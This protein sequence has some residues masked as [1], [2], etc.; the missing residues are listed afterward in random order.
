MKNMENI[1]W[2]INFIEVCTWSVNRRNTSSTLVSGDGK[3]E[4]SCGGEKLPTDV[5]YKTLLYLL[6]LAQNN[7][8]NNGDWMRIIDLTQYTPSSLIKGI[9]GTSNNPNQEAIDRFYDTLKR[10]SNMRIK[11][12]QSYHVHDASG[13]KGK[14]A[15]SFNVLS[16]SRNLDPPRIAFD[17]LFL[18]RL[19]QSLHYRNLSLNEYQRISNPTAMRLFELLEK[20]FLYNRPWKINAKRLAEK[21]G[22]NAKHISHITL[23][24]QIAI[25]LIN[26]ATGNRYELEMKT[27]DGKET[28]NVDNGCVT[29]KLVGTQYVPAF[30]KPQKKEEQKKTSKPSPRP[31][32]SDL[33]TTILSAIPAT[34][35]S[36]KEVTRILDELIRMKG[37][38]AA[39][40]IIKYCLSK[41]PRSFAAYLVTMSKKTNLAILAETEIANGG[42]LSQRE[43]QMHYRLKRCLHYGEDFFLEKCEKYEMDPV[44]VREWIDG[45]D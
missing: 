3:Y 2:D 12:D 19:R 34:D 26:E 37:E 8:D 27:A 31:F 10:Y 1:R 11:F 36:D 14:V 29:F 41:K 35:R 32:D 4:V 42:L 13:A 6:C 5:D 25:N 38:N 24:L 44:A 45:R 17:E 15:E 40:V 9:K 18:D 23:K 43:L 7:I 39:A 21:I 16:F 22:I 30:Q 33:P 20:S 28:V